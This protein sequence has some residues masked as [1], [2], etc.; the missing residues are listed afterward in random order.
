MKKPTWRAVLCQWLSPILLLAATD[1]WA[2]CDFID[3]N[4]ANSALG[5]PAHFSW[6]ADGIQSRIP[7]S[8]IKQTA[9]IHLPCSNDTWQWF[10]TTLHLDFNTSSANYVDLLSSTAVSKQVGYFDSAMWMMA[11]N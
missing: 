10:E 5:N 7:I 4:T 6:T 3:P 11:S 8:S 1:S 2:Q 9:N